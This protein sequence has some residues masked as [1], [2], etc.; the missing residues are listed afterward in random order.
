M[1]VFY[2]FLWLD[3]SEFSGIVQLVE[4]YRVTSLTK[5]VKKNG[6][7]VM[8]YTSK[9]MIVLIQINKTKK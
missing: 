8:T 7:Q 2:Q 1:K 5:E 6:Y 9:H 4:I 3:T